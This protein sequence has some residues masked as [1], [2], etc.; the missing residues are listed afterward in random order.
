[1]QLGGICCDCFGPIVSIPLPGDRTDFHIASEKLGWVR[2]LPIIPKLL[3]FNSG[4]FSHC[5][6]LHLIFHPTLGL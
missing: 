1:M 3:F 4:K 6:I 5:S 2:L